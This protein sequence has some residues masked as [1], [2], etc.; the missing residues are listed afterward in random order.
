MKKQFSHRLNSSFRAS[1]GGLFRNRGTVLGFFVAGGVLVILLIVRVAFPAVFISLAEPLWTGGSSMT[2]GVGNV[3]AGFTNKSTLI[4]ENA[5]LAQEVATLQSEN[6]VLTTRS[7]DLTQLL[8]GQAGSSNTIAAGVLVRP[9]VSAYDTLVVSAGSDDGVAKDAESFA[10]GG[11]PI[12]VVQSTTPHVSI[13]QLYSSAG[14]TTDGWIGSN[15]I[16]ITLTGGGAGTFEATIPKGTAVVVG[17]SVYVAGP[18]ALPIGT[19][20][21]IDANPSSPTYVL[22]IQPLVNLFSLTWVQIAR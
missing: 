9:P 17:D 18:G 7:Q 1:G 19:V 10:K 13:I 20:A 11:I 2:A 6:A 3:F 12:G 4:K 8:G 16:P 14:R 21:L 5:A 15:R 22:H